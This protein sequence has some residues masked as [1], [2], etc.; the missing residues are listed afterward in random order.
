[1]EGVGGVSGTMEHNDTVSTSDTRHLHPESVFRNEGN[2]WTVEYAGTVT[3]L[4]DSRGAQYLAH[5]LH[6]PGQE[7]VALELVQVARGA[8]DGE[9]SRVSD[10]VAAAF[11]SG[12]GPLLDAQAK[13]AYKE[14]LAEL[15]DELH[16]AQAMNDIGRAE[17]SQTE[18]ELITQQVAGAVGLGGRDR[19]VGS[20]VERARSTVTKGIKSAIAKIGAVNPNAGRHFAR[21]IHTGYFC[22]YMPDPDD[23]PRWVF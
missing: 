13:A 18:I 2:Y 1:M 21:T 15:R 16:D 22:V 11:D 20:D 12:H 7:F 3:R 14:R 4:K 19:A 9:E 17:R 8:I 23:C 10:S 5:L 6:H